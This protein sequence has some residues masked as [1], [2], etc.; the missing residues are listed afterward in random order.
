MR[1]VVTGDFREPLL[2]D[3]DKATGILITSDDGKPNVVYRVIGNGKGWIRYTKGEDAAFDEIA[4]ALGL[5]K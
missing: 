3:T 1:V 2:L 5:T 4:R